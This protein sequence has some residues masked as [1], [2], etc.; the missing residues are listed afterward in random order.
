MVEPKS[1][2][3]VV[4]D[5]PQAP[6]AMVLRIVAAERDYVDGHIGIVTERLNGM[7]TASK[8]LSDT[9]NRTPTE[10]TREVNHLQSIMDERFASIETQFKERDTRAERE[11]RDNKVAVDAA[12]AAQ[13]EA[14]SEQNKGN[15]LAI[16]KSEKATA[17]T[18]KTNQELAKSEINGLRK[19]GEDGKV[20]QTEVDD[21][22]KSRLGAV[23]ASLVGLAAA[24]QN[25]TETRVDRRG[26]STVLLSLIAALL[27]L[28]QIGVVLY[29]SKK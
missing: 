20:R 17:E 23:E 10:I 8:L 3:E 12:F 11:S 21:D 25:A 19:S 14:A 22:M 24:K 7:D 5:P 4:A 1:P 2:H 29:V 13:K 18:I 16:D 28:V 6:T 9:V 26:D 15:N 27:I